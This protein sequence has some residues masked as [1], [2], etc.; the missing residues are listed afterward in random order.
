[1][2]SISASHDD[3]PAVGEVHQSGAFLQRP[4]FV[5]HTFFI[6]ASEGRGNLPSEVRRELRVCGY[7]FCEQGAAWHDRSCRSSIGY[8]LIEG[9]SRKTILS[10][11]GFSKGRGIV[12]Q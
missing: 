5:L 9:T 1:A 2:R 7:E 4:V 3:S 12:M 11:I 8:A 10:V 6:C